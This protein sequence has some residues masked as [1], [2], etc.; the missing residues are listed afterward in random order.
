MIDNVLFITADQ[1]R[2]E[3]LSALGH[4]IVKTPHLDEL[5]R[6]GTLFSRHHSQATP[7][8]PSRA[9]LYTGLYQH[10][11]RTVTNGTPL[12]DRHTNIAREV[13]KA[14]HDPAL[15]GYTDIG[16]DPRG[17]DTDDPE[18]WNRSGLLP[19]MKPE[20]RMDDNQ[21][22]WVHALRER[23]Y[24]VDDDRRSLYR[25]NRDGVDP[26]RGSTFAPTWYRAED[27]GAA[28]LTDEAIAYISARETT[29][30]FAHISYLSPHPPFIAPE[31]YNDLYDA[32]DMPMPIRCASAEEE[33]KQHPW[34][35]FFLSNP[36]D[37]P[38][39]YG[40]INKDGHAHRESEIRQIKATY[41]AMMTEI[42]AQIG[43]LIAHLKAT[44]AWER[45]L[46]VFTSDHG[47]HLGDHWMMSKF[48]YY[49]QTFSIPLIIRDP[50][51]VSD[52]VRGQ[53]IDALTENVD[54][55]PTILEWLGLEVPAACDGAS[56]LEFCHGAEVE[57][58]R[59]EAHAAF[60][61][62]FFPGLDNGRTLGLGPDEC[63]ANLIFDRRYKYVHFTGLP[64]LFFDL[65]A[66]PHEF[67]NLADDPSYQGL[68]LEYVQKLM[69]W[70]MNHDDRAFANTRLG[71]DG[72]V[73][74]N[75]SRR[76]L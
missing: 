38:Y 45:T 54:I 76:R 70:R 8:G 36:L 37:S 15:F 23:G 4:P 30:W 50:R 44:G 27:T 63:T 14:G 24:E 12:D 5:A 35:D 51:P 59:T 65:E 49:K 17:R 10:N 2:G 6:E 60:D 11:H 3:C 21:L 46:F 61:F 74:H 32:A 55:M 41:F 57:D 40:A 34:V 25:P 68:V 42:D 13:R 48:S 67:N 1:W 52:P 73:E 64:P 22:P 18:L 58:W 43:R 72:M 19:G 29:P 56:L 75:P 16:A 66:D 47:E 62:R 53:T 33:A 26:S 31:P 20:V 9:S 71:A 28:F 7:C 69:S 39:T